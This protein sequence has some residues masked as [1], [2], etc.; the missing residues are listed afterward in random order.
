M[1][2]D[3]KV[4][5]PPPAGV[6]PGAHRV[7]AGGAHDAETCPAC[8]AIRDLA[9]AESGVAARELLGR[10]PGEVRAPSPSLFPK[11]YQEVEDAIQQIWT[12]AKR[13]L[14]L[15]MQEGSRQ[16]LRALAQILAAVVP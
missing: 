6:P 16:Q 14:P 4:G 15:A 5:T 3:D 1:P 9:G 13:T 8:K 2:D 10:T 12:I 7:T 11:G